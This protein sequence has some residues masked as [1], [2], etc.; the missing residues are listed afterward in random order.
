MNLS[1]IYRAVFNDLFQSPQGLQPYTLYSR[2]GLQPDDAVDF[3]LKYKADDI[4]SISDDNKLSLTPK[5]RKCINQVIYSIPIFAPRDKD[6]NISYRPC[7]PREDIFEPFVPS[8]KFLDRMLGR[9]IRRLSKDVATLLSDIN[10]LTQ[11]IENIKENQNLPES[12]I[13]S[14]VAPPDKG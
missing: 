11:T 10:E 2:Y 4:I 7:S 9:D 1:D 6:Y 14:E 12:E 8:S 3:I 13:R 5:G